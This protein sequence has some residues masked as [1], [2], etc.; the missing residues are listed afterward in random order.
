MISKPQRPFSLVDP[1]T[2]TARFGIGSE[3]LHA[4]SKTIEKHF[5]RDS[6]F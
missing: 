1:T 2:E 5:V 6:I 3:I 4:V